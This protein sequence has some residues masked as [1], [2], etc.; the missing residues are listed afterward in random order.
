[1]STPA[2][3]AALERAVRDLLDAWAVAGDAWRDGT[4]EEFDRDHLQGLHWRGRHAMKAV[5]ELSQLCSEA[6]RRCQ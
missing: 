5:A 3:E 4:R 6:L 2:D 1:M